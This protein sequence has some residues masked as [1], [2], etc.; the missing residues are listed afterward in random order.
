VEELI[1]EEEFSALIQGALKLDNWS[2]MSG[3]CVILMEPPVY[4]HIRIAVC[5]R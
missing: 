2:V 3:L 5:M 1:K 4:G